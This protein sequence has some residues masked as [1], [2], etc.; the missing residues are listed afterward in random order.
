MTESDMRSLPI[1]LDQLFA[2]R[3]AIARLGEMD[4]AGWWNTRGLLAASGAFALRRGLPRTHHFAQARV[5]F[6]VA[7]QRCQAVFNATNVL[8]LWSMPALIEDAFEDRWPAFIRAAEQWAPH[9]A[10]VAALRGHDVP[11][12]LRDVGLVDDT[13]ADAAKRLRR[14]PEGNAVALPK[15]PLNDRALALLAAGFAQAEPGRL[16]V[17]YL[18]VA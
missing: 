1:D 9:F 13:V 12:A 3:L 11:G 16:A 10:R 4:N 8:T 7:A 2:L 14:S 6:A 5:V 17:P 18:Q 15:L